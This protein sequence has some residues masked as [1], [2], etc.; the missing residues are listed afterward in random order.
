MAKRCVRGR[1]RNCTKLVVKKRIIHHKSSV[2]S[3]QEINFRTQREGVMEEVVKD[4]SH[5]WF[6]HK[7]I[8]TQG[9]QNQ[10]ILDCAKLAAA[11]VCE[12]RGSEYSTQDK[13]NGE[14]YLILSG[15]AGYSKKGMIY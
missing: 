15:V 9:K 10:K 1:L 13:K 7:C 5:G 4:D 2:V 6:V 14:A 11:E 8:N 12:L 3:R